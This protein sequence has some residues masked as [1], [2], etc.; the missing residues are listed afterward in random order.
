M[1]KHYLLPNGT[2]VKIKATKREANLITTKLKGRE[3][4]KSEYKSKLK[5]I[6]TIARTLFY[7]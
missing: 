2:V 5:I 1:L 3:I 4:S 6:N 7:A